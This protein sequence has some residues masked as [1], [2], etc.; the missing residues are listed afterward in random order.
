MPDPPEAPDPRR[1]R[2]VLFRDLLV[3]SVKA[4]LEAFRDLILIPIALGAGVIGLIF[5]RNDP[6]A[7]FRLVIDGGRRFDRWLDLF[8]ERKDGGGVAAILGQ[9][10]QAL[11]HE[12]QRGGLTQ[13]AKESIDQALDGLQEALEG[14]KDR[15]HDSVSKVQKKLA[16]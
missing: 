3:F 6:G 9:V 2:W 7:L 1:D 4:A 11:I 14:P 15:A 12:H 8:D 13:Q 16:E 10:E 5:Q